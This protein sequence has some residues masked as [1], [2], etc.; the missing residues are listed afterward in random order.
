MAEKRKKKSQKRAELA[1]RVAANLHSFYGEPPDRFLCPTC[2]A[3]IPLSEPQQITKAHIIPSAAGGRE[4]TLLCKECNRRFGHR[5]DKW[6]GRYLD[7]S[8]SGSLKV[9]GSPDLVTLGFLTAGYLLWFREL[10]YSWALQQHLGPVRDL[11][12]GI[13]ADRAIL[14]RCTVPRRDRFPRPWVASERSAR[15]WC[16]QPDSQTA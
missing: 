13:S 8:R 15:K 7:A 1:A 5:Q 4:S 9:E 11:I 6:L 10:G 3:R 2:L 12:L 14:S 16:S